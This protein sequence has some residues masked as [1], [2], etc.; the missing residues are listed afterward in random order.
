[1]N[2]QKSYNGTTR[3]HFNLHDP[4]QYYSTGARS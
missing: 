4:I 3:V 2:K 1:V